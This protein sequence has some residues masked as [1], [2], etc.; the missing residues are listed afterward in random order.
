MTRRL[1]ISEMWESTVLA[2]GGK[3]KAS[4]QTYETRKLKSTLTGNYPDLEE[5]TSKSMWMIVKPPPDMGMR[6]RMCANMHSE[7]T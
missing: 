3:G 4:V 5:D 6:A 2:A 7:R 1:A